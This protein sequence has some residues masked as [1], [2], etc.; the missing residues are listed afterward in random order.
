MN[1]TRTTFPADFLWGGGFAAAQMEGAYLEGGKGLCISDLTQNVADLPLA[2][3]GNKEMTSD[4]IQAAIKDTE[5]NYPKRRGIDFYHTYK[6]DLRLLG[7]YGLGLKS[8][9]TSINW[10]RIFPNGDD[11]EPNEEG[12]RFYDDLIDEILANG[13][14]PMI[15]MSH[16]EMPVNLILKYRGWY[17]KE[18]ID[19]FE[20]YGQVILDRYHDRVKLWINVNQINLISHES[21]LHL[22]I[23]SDTVNNMQEAKYQGVV[24]EMIGCA[25]ISQYA[26]EHYPD[27]K[28]GCMLCGGYDYPATCKPEDVLAALRHNQMEVFYSDV[29]LRGKIPGYAWHYFE[30]KGYRIEISE[31]EE[32]MLKNTSDYFTFSY[33]YSGIV[34]QAHFEEGNRVALNKEIPATDWGWSIDPTGLRILLNVF[35]DRYQCPIYITENGIGLID[36]LDPDGHIHDPQRV[37]FYRKHIEAMKA[38]IADGVDLRGY[39]VWGPLDIV[40]CS[41]SEMSKRYGFI[42]VD[43]DDHGAGSG[44]R[45]K[46][47][48][49]AWMQKVIATH[50]EDLA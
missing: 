8:Y 17:Q 11:A 46:K 48:S 49:F 45:I 1:R 43:L 23:P 19:C 24:N 15:T 35:Y 40:S 33:Y 21:I 5:G 29:L 4:I 44:R 9:R 26:H 31:E 27:V 12:L 30:E 41:S 37:D 28:I 36:T 6:E 50:G 34:D 18:T 13:M 47:D 22:G 20:R 38:A 42:Y 10:A 14:E 2:K 7:K 16:Y 32:A 25:R 3:K 39:Y